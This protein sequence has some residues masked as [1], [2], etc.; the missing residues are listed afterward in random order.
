VPGRP[1]P[2]AAL[3]PE[4]VT[5]FAVTALAHAGIYLLN[6][7]LPLHVVALDGSKTQVGL[8]FTVST[9]TSMVLRPLVGGFNDHWGFR[10]VA[11]PGA[12][13]LVAATL[14]LSLAGSPGV[15]VALMAG[16][17]LGNA[18]VTTSAGVHVAG[19]GTP[20]QRGEA[21]SL[22]YV[23]TSLGCA[24]G[25]PVGF[26]LYRSYGMAAVFVTA[27]AAL[28]AAG[29]LAARIGGGPRPVAE[30]PPGAFRVLSLRAAP[31]SAALVLVTL[32]HSVLYA[33]L[34]LYALASGRGASVG[35]FFAIYSA[36]VI[37]CRFA[38]RGL[39]D[40][41][42]R[43]PVAALAMGSTALGYA[44]LAVPPTKLTLLAGALLL[45][46][47][48]ALLYP[49]LVA[50]LVDR[51]PEAERGRALGTLSASWDVGA[52]GGAL[53]IG[54]TVERA[55]YAAGFVLAAATAALGLGAFLAV[56]RRR[57]AR[58]DLPRPA[59]GVSF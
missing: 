55:S 19:A 26:F 21:I 34:P 56:E 51:V 15:V 7:V 41:V 28:A 11:L 36:C 46:G 47:G 4:V 57:T 18:L 25:P 14:G 13:A 33:F 27:L 48:A 58:R 43:A 8:L 40:R 53:L 29:G 52:A 49:T 2:I 1:S 35:W 16:I 54:L 38:L 10:R 23:A 17:G 50:L 39:S 5:C 12:V 30:R 44:V 24:V 45:G 22:Y 6:A 3:S 59:P 31:V 32:G 20:A 9:V 37:A 42:G